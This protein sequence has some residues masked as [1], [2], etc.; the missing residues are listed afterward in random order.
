M[1][2]LNT[3][4]QSVF[5]E[6]LN[7]TKPLV[8]G[9]DFHQLKLISVAQNANWSLLTGMVTEGLVPVDS[10]AQASSLECNLACVLDLECLIRCSQQLCN[11][12]P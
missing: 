5:V 8:N 1:L 10:K 12:L 7:C 6:Y 3:F 11:S 4:S 9:Q 2:Y